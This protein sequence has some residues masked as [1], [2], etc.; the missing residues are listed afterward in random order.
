MNKGK[1]KMVNENDNKK[2]K[3][4][5]TEKK[6]IPTKHVRNI[7]GAIVTPFVHHLRLVTCHLSPHHT[8][9]YFEIV[10]CD[11]VACT[12]IVRGPKYVSIKF[13]ESFGFFFCI[14][15]FSLDMGL[16]KAIN[17]WITKCVTLTQMALQL[18]G[19]KNRE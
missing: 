17:N 13:Y 16:R 8:L 14:L 18:I 5:K 15:K 9:W 11:F 6:K 1:L 19:K 2:Q 7:V 12:E 3:K 4:K 10:S